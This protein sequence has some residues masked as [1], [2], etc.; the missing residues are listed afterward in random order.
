MAGGDGPTAPAGTGSWRVGGLWVRLASSPAAAR[1]ERDRVAWLAAASGTDVE[2]PVAGTV[3]L[4]E[5]PWLVVDGLVG[6]AALHP[7]RQPEPDRVPVELGRALR[8]LHDLDVASCPFVRSWD[9]ELEELSRAI[10]S[11]ALDRERLP[12]PYRRYQPDELLRLAVTGRPAG[13]DDQVVGHGRPLAQHLLLDDGR[14]SGFLALDRLAVV[15]RHRDLAVIHRHLL[16]LFGA[17]AVFAFYDGYGSDP[18][19]VWLD[20]AIAVEVIDDAVQRR[21]VGAGP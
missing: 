11:G 6:E 19:L 18:D 5:G 16:T 4:V 8:R 15:D 14:V 2:L 21:P 9:D 3:V 1:A 13:G 10:G 20:H 12:D 7:E 17:E